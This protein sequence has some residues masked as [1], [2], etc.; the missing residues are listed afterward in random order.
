MSATAVDVYYTL[1]CDELRLSVEFALGRGEFG[2]IGS[3]PE[4][5]ISLPLVGFSEEEC[6]ICLDEVGVLWLVRGVREIP[7][8]IDP[9]SY[10]RA[11]PY[12]FLI[13]EKVEESILP[14]HTTEAP[15]PL[16]EET[17][18]SE[19][20]SK[21]TSRARP[22]IAVLLAFACLVVA[23]WFANHL[24]SRHPEGGKQARTTPT[25]AAEKT[26]ALERDA[27]IIDP[28]KE[29]ERT[30]DP[31]K[32]IDVQT[33]VAP[34]VAGTPAPTP[35]R[36]PERM[37]LEKLAVRVVPC[38]FL[39]QVFDGSGSSIATGTGFSVSADGLVATNH[40]V[41]EN[42]QRYALVTS[43][44]AKY[45][46]AEVIVS[47]SDTDLAIL[48]I[49][50]KDLPYLSLAESSKVPIGKRV[51]VYGNP[52][53][54]A[55]SLSEGIISASGRNWP[56]NSPTEAM[57]NKGVLI[58]TTT[59]ISP[60]S[61]G[62]PLFDA[63]GKVIGVMTLTLLRNSQS[64]NFAVPVEALKPL[65]D[66]AKSSWSSA[67]PR[68]Q[69][70]GGEPSAASAEVDAIIQDDPAYRR[71]SQQMSVGNWIEAIKAARFL[72]DKYLKSSFA[73]FQYGY[74]AAMLKLDHQAELSY[75]KAIEFNPLNHVAW[76]NLGVVLNNQNQQQSALL[77]YEK[78]VSLHPEFP[79]AWNNIVLINFFLGNWAK[80]TTA[81]DT[82]GRIDLKLAREC[83]R[84]L[85]NFRVPDADFRE[86]LE[87]TLAR[88]VGKVALNGHLK[89]RVVGVSPDDP[90]SVRSGPGV[91]FLRVI[92]I[93]NGTE[94]FV[95][96][97]GRMNG[98][99]EWLPIDYGNSSGWVVSKYLQAE[100]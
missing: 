17:N 98:S 19:E 5:E 36:E 80:A 3:S 63:E 76:N 23:A 61:S 40:H 7:I 47:D 64:L 65:I 33:P 16:P 60:G 43:Q 53:G 51:A 72:A 1:S 27:S 45:D 69:P 10:F 87:R 44:G 82:L 18:P 97:G 81:L 83:A 50:A 78:A 14:P 25:P 15:A 94:V 79:L 9:P 29:L 89:F 88:K 49:A 90:L 4:M 56:E 68:P 30:P 95:T 20:L 41:V 48:K 84:T 75:I 26:K 31:S 54:L 93:A 46:N 55:G 73:H 12:K 24:F 39:I 99:T 67:R 37:D 62:S 91:S 59:P 28:K 96:G 77:A 11:G 66:R 52:L 74:C 38:V 34:Q 2:R 21:K 35:T 22:M 86:A 8:R 57:P 70:S 92:S 85:V 71:M 6:R 58:Q 100:E 32:L 13:R 42:G